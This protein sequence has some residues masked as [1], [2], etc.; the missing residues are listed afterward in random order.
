V[1][2][3]DSADEDPAVAA[4]SADGLSGRLVAMATVGQ[5]AKL[6][7]ERALSR[8]LTPMSLALNR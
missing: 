7:A 3:H 2:L 5:V 8:A 4:R 1:A 6:L